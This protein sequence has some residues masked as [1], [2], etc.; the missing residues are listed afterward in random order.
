MSSVVV[1]RLDLP[2]AWAWAWAWAWAYVGAVPDVHRN[3]LL[4]ML[5]FM[6]DMA[7]HEN[8]TIKCSRVCDFVFSVF[9]F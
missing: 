4:Y 3:V 1:T 7:G 6:I 2:A 9:F 5:R 8:G